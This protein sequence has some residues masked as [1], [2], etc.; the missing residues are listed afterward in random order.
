M[1]VGVGEWESVRV[2]TVS[3]ADQEYARIIGASVEGLDDEGLKRLR[4]MM[5]A[6]L[7]FGATSVVLDS[8]LYNVPD[9]VKPKIESSYS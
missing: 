6:E 1:A 7:G 4:A 8:M 5:A 9:A 3:A 2:A